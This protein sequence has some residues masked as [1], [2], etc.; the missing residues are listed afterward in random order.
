MGILPSTS[1]LIPQTARWERAGGSQA[2]YLPA[3]PTTTSACVNG[4]PCIECAEIP[5]RLPSICMNPGAAATQSPTKD[6]KATTY[7]VSNASHGGGGHAEGGQ[8][9]AWQPTQ[10]PRETPLSLPQWL[11]SDSLSWSAQHRALAGSISTLPPPGRACQ[12]RTELIRQ[13]EVPLTLPITAGG[14]ESF[15]GPLGVQ[16]MCRWG[17]LG[18]GLVG[19]VVLGWWLDL[20]ILEVFSNLW[21]YD[22]M[23][24]PN[25][26]ILWTPGLECAAQHNAPQSYQASSKRASVVAGEI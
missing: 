12:E 7:N 22:S 24:L 3:L 10:L 23:N 21:F 16:K 5:L 9:I 1:R 26:G 11:S 4:W 19:M 14:H 2:D 6:W 17:T 20:M 18:Y 13:K 8:W 15:K 25:P